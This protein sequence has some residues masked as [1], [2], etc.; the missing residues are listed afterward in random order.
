MGSLARL[1]MPY[2]T[3]YFLYCTGK[4]P[5]SKAIQD[6]SDGKEGAVP[7]STCLSTSIIVYILY[8]TTQAVFQAAP[9]TGLFW[10]PILS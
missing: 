5:N 4:P 7:Y 2:M 3:M 8:S 1:D 6:R 9:I 10:T